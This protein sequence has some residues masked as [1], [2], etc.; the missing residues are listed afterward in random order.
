MTQVTKLVTVGSVT[1]RD[2]KKGMQIYEKGVSNSILITCAFEQTH[3][4]LLAC[5]G[6]DTRISVFTVNR[7]ED[8]DGLNKVHELSKHVGL[9]TACSFLDENFLVSASNDSTLILWDINKDGTSVRQ[10]LDHK[11]EVFCLDTCGENSN[12][13]VSGSGDTTMRYWDVRMKE[14]CVK[15]FEDNKHPVTAVRF[16]PGR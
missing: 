14:A 2:L 11:T 10:L 15:V 3:S 8:E 4:Q 5:G 13:L 12:L 7:K 1:V 9:V 6:L 16:M